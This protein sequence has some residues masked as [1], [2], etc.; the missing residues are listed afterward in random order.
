[1]DQETQKLLSE[2]KDNLKCLAVAV[3]QNSQAIDDLRTAI[4]NL[5]LAIEK[6]S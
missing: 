5:M 6:K 4:R 3:G 1:M 2:I